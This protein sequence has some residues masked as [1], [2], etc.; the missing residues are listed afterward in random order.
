MNVFEV[1]LHVHV[2]YF[3]LVTYVK[4]DENEKELK[5]DQQVV[6]LCVSDICIVVFIQWLRLMI[7]FISSK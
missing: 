6:T 7:D 4:V 5:N 3:S 2:L 1:E